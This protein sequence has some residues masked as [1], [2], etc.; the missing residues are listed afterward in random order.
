MKQP[1]AVIF[2]H[3]HLPADERLALADRVRLTVQGRGH[4]FIMARA[5]LVGADGFHGRGA[6]P[7]DVRFHTAPVH[8]EEEIAEAMLAG[9]D[10]LFLS[11][12][13]RTASHVGEPPLSP[14]RAIALAQACRSPLFALGGMNEDRAKKLEG[15]SFQGFGAIDAFMKEPEA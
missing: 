15:T 3:D 1:L 6:R 7:S 11:P 4:L 9:A 14:S 10:A 12:M 2:R 5:E 13:N 8:D